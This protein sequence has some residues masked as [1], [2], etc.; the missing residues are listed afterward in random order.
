[1]FF[2]G[3]KE[4]KHNHIHYYRTLHGVIGM[5]RNPENTE[6]VFDIEEGLRHLEA[7]Q[8]AV[9]HLMSIPSVRA[10]AEERYLRPIPDVDEL[11]TLPAGTLG[12][13]YAFHL[14]NHGFDPDYY[15][16]I[17]VETDAH[18]LALR[19][20]Q[21]HDIWHTV[22]G[23]G[24]DQLGELA[25]KACELA[26][27]RRPMAAVITAGGLLRY[28]L[29]EPEQLPGVMQ[30]LYQGYTI[31]SNARPLLA[32]KWEEQWDRRLDELRV[33]LNVQ[34]GDYLPGPEG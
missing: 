20:R 23:I 4:R 12:Y 18:Y 33:E 19:M 6:S 8:V 30:S 9:D 31:G 29:K 1:M 24:P 10:M 21:T 22:I 13:H 5:L 26:Q 28:L 25:V 15:R 17:D 16:K 3:L 7:S 11:R 14:H 34:A 2:R 32:Q 27:T